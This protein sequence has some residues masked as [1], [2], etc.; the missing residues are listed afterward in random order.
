MQEMDSGQTLALAGRVFGLVY[1]EFA[2]ASVLRLWQTNPQGG[3]P[4]LRGCSEK[5]EPFHTH[6]Q[7]SPARAP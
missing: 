6:P 2:G 3:L 5:H 7:D 1:A 4:L